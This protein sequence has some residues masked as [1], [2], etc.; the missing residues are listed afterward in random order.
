MNPT[1]YLDLD[2]TI[3]HTERIGEL[4]PVLERL[5]PENAALHDGY[6][7]REQYFV[8]PHLDDGDEKTYYYDLAR[9]L[10]DAGLSLDEAF[11]VLRTELGEGRFE[12]EGALGLVQALKKLGT[13]KILTYGEDVYQKFK[14]SLCPSVAGLEVLTTVDP[15]VDYLN[16]HAKA[17]D[18][19]V[20]DKVLSGLN[21]EVRAVHIQHDEAKPAD[22]HSLTEV[23]DFIA[24]RETRQQG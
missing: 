19:I 7:H 21:A 18:W 24:R 5:Y 20:D 3:F 16:A 11:A 17:G 22:A 9:Q 10:S 14:A 1:F 8:F 12:F 4:F 23:A 6:A 2:R 13:V 15:K